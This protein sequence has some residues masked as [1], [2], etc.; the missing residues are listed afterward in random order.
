MYNMD[1]LVEDVKNLDD[2]VEVE[3]LEK[4]DFLKIRE[5]L[6]RI[7][8]ASTKE[9]KK[10]YQ[11]C[12]ILFRSNRYYVVHFKELFILDGKPSTFRYSDMARRNGIVKL[13]EKWELLKVKNADLIEEP[14]V[15]LESI[16]VLPYKKKKDWI[17]C[18]KY[19]VKK[20]RYIM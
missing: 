3:L 6:T 10:L 1:D 16:R 5:T 4:D 12:H 17:F 14:Q 15:K 18:V 2:M 11:S 19:D 8:I 20:V 13:L 7:G 9:E